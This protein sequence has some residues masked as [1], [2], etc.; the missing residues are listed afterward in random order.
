MNMSK[1]REF[2][3][4]VRGHAKV[5]Y[6]ALM[7][8]VNFALEANDYSRKTLPFT[9]HYSWE[10]EPANIVNPTEKDIVTTVHIIS[11]IEGELTTHGARAKS[12]MYSHDFIAR[13]NLLH[14][15]KHEHATL[16]KQLFQLSP[17]IPDVVAG[18]QFTAEASFTPKA[19]S[20]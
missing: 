6:D 11:R 5:A 19:V 2:S 17:A 3:A 7:A 15:L 13:V 1:L 20:K 8:D 12:G 16:E 10:N 18:K 14:A 9:I 4:T